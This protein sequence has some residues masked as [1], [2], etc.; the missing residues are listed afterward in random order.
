MSTDL[1][2][3]LRQLNA[4]GVSRLEHLELLLLLSRHS[5][6]N[7]DAERVAGSSVIP[8]PVAVDALAHLCKCELLEQAPGP[9]PTYR[10]GPRSELPL[11]VELRTVYERDRI[12]VVNAFYACNLESLRS[13]A[14]AFRIRRPK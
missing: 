4:R 6:T 9:A 5:T 13:F 3:I 12:A 7:W 1:T 2:G 10:L 11:L 14:S 8:R